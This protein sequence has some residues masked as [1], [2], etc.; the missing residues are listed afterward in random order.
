MDGSS[1]L[2][3]KQVFEHSVIHTKG[4]DIHDGVTGGKG[5]SKIGIVFF[6]CF[7]S[8]LFKPDKASRRVSKVRDSCIRSCVFR[9][10]NLF[11]SLFFFCLCNNDY[12][13]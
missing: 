12:T 11:L 9:E 8:I 4:I 1:D 10:Y 6:F 7:H 2:P 3:R 13:C 5:S